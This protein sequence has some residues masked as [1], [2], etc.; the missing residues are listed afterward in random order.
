[1][2]PEKLCS[3]LKRTVKDRSL[4]KLKDTTKKC[5]KKKLLDLNRGRMRE[6]KL[7]KLNSQLKILFNSDSS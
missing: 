2:T 6:I 5:I 3:R 7:R 1:M 4:S